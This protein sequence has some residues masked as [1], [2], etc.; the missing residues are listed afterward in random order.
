MQKNVGYMFRKTVEEGWM[1]M[2]CRGISVIR[3]TGG[4]GPSSIGP[5]EIITPMSP[6]KGQQMDTL[7]L[8]DYATWVLDRSQVSKRLLIFF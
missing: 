6:K 2:S 1:S 3:E 8:E 5:Y 4:E 7:H